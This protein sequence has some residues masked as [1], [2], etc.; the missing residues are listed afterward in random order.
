M[1]PPH[2]TSSI[3]CPTGTVFGKRLACGGDLV[4]GAWGACR[5]KRDDMAAAAQTTQNHNTLMPSHLTKP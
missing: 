2:D 4:L 1:G 5:Q 3:V